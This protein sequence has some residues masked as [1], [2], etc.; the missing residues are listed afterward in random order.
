MSSRI[1]QLTIFDAI[2]TYIVIN[3]DDE[4]VDAIFNTENALQYKKY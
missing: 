3:K 4:S 2:Y 1:A